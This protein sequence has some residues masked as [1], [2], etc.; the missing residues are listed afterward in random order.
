MKI[1]VLGGAANM[2]QPALNYLV[3]LESV[4]E[5]VLTDLNE[6]RLIEIAERLGEKATTK[7]LNVT[8]KDKLE[9][10][11]TNANLVMNFIGPYYRFKTNAMEAAINSGVNYIDLCD[12]YDVTIE[13]LKLDQ[14]AKE[15]GVTAI[16]GMG[17]SPGVTNIF[18]R[19]GAEALDSADE[20]NTYWVVGDAEPSGFGALVHMFHIIKGKV[21]TF[22]DGELQWIRAFQPE[23]AKKLDFGDPVG[24]V[25]LYH[26]GHPEPI[27]LPKY[28]PN[29]KKVTNQGALLPEF[30]NPMFKTLVDLGMTSEET[31]PF[32]GEQVAPLDFL[33][34]LFEY[35]QEEAKKRP[36]RREK[37]RSVG[38]TRIEVIGEKDGKKAIY[39]FTK[40]GYTTMDHGTSMPAGLV[41]GMILNEEITMKGVIAPECLDPKKI[42]AALQEIGHF[43]G[44]KDFIVT[45]TIHD[46]V[47][48]G[49][50]TDDRMFP[51]LR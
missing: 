17:A 5:I 12:D 14:L 22:L 47:D 16:T 51:E 50:I 23:T 1:V 11:I 26:V 36:R 44:E 4:K 43:E 7:K 3:K 40:S 9:S 29:I 46:K 21:P 30:Q 37:R 10:I 2:A 28:I 32:K 8:D 31:F 33:L 42:I 18:A 34:S 19:L 24:E 49:S 41:A 13:A 48:T 25:T 39:T 20:I 15:K 45:R 6:K 38:A 35:K 27:T